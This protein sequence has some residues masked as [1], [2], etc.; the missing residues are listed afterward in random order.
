M[1]YPRLKVARNLLR[2]DGVILISIDD[3]EQ[4]NLRFVAN[5][6][7]GEENFVAVL[8]WDRNRKNDAK[9]FSVGHEYMLVYFKNKSLLAEQKVIFRGQK[10]AWR[11]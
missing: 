5:E 2:D 6:V 9:Y 3:V 11:S 4:P 1:I 10:E 8:V 7:F